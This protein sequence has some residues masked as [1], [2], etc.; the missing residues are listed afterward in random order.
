MTKRKVHFALPNLH[1]PNA[2]ARGDMSHWVGGTGGWVGGHL[3]PITIV[4]ATSPGLIRFTRNSDSEAVDH[5][6]CQRV[7]LRG[8]VYHDVK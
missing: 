3:T 8:R 5:S 7:R 4:R 2:H 1:N 6:C